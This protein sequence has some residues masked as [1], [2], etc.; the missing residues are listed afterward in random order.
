[1]NVYGYHIHPLELPFDHSIM[2]VVKHILPEQNLHTAAFGFSILS[3]LA[4]LGIVFG[5]LPKMPRTNRL[6]ALLIITILFPVVSYDYTLLTAHIMWGIVAIAALNHPNPGHEQLK[7]LTLWMVG[8][9]I[10]IA[11]EG[12]LVVGTERLGGILKAIT[13]TLLLVFALTKPLAAEQP[14]TDLG[15]S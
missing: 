2:A 14:R 6:L 4:L 3:G 7:R 12:F 13:L 15:I 5:I 10:V 8:L 11:P 1:M 9:A